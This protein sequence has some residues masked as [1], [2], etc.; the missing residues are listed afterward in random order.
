MI[1]RLLRLFI[2]MAYWCG[3]LLRDCVM[4]FLRRPLPGR[5]IVV[6]YKDKPSRY[7]ERFVRPVVNL[8]RRYHVIPLESRHSLKPGG[9]CVVLTFDDGLMS[10]A[11][12]AFP[13][14]E[15]RQIPVAV[16]IPAGR[17]GEVLEEGSDDAVM[18]AERMAA[19]NPAIFTIGSHGL[20]HSDLTALS[21]AAARD[22][23][24]RSRRALS[25]LLKRD[26]QYMSFPFGS[27]KEQ[28]ILWARE[29]G[30]E[31]IFTSLAHPAFQRPD[32]FVSGRVQVHPKDWCVE[33]W[34]KI[35]GGYSW[36]GSL[37]YRSWKVGRIGG[38]LLNLPLIRVRGTSGSGV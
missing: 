31:H 28:H 7:R 21:D 10:A 9:R 8:S 6:Y 23:I 3:Q 5:C 11:E 12:N 18:T 30:Y 26:V 20:T 4:S 36:L 32:E 34:L 2:S 37:S 22:E 35:A 1:R 33:F 25:D 27:F 14:L 19:L 38:R 13:V 29:A 17:L 16:F 24:V 15:K